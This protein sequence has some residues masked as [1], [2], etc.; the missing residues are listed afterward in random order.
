MAPTINSD[1]THCI[2]LPQLVV[3]GDQSAGKSSVLEG[4]T[5]LPFPRQDGLR[6][7][8]PTE[9]VLTH[10]DD[11][12]TT[13]ETKIIPDTSRPTEEQKRLSA[14]KCDLK[15]FRQDLPMVVE[16]VGQMMGLR[17]Y[18][19]LTGP[20]FAYGLLR[21][22][23]TGPIGVHLTVVDLPGLISVPNEEQ[24]EIDVDNVHALVE[25]YIKNSRTIILAVVQAN[26]DVANQSIIQKSKNFDRSGRR[27]VGIIMKPDLINVGTENRIAA[28]AKNQDTTKLKLGF[29]LLKNPSP[30]ELR[31][32]LTLEQRERSER[33]F[34]T[35]SPWKEQQLDADRIGVL[36]LRIYLQQLLDRHI[37]QEMPKVRK[38]INALLTKTQNDLD[39]LGEERPTAGHQR[40]FLSRLAM[41]FNHLTEAALKGEY[42]FADRAFF[43]DE[44]HDS[45][46]IRLR[47]FVHNANTEFANAMREYGESRKVVPTPV[48]P[49]LDQN[50]GSGEES[51]TSDTS[52]VESDGD[53]ETPDESGVSSFR[54][55]QQ[56]IGEREMEEFVLKVGR[57]VHKLRAAA[58]LT[59]VALP[60]HERPGVARQLQ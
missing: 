50:A 47:A 54:K 1:T 31:E 41:R 34:F 38:E 11:P 2:D 36:K 55:S 33:T 16:E 43:S 12:T 26:N 7:R 20:T 19:N 23:V 9:I 25:W 42:Q 40:M 8:F 60:A 52:P 18:G 21:I 44:T 49:Q 10:T 35:T 22:K 45:D 3:C 48:E 28:L 29:F 30:K 14:Y 32:G 58:L 17:G 39:A 27:T 51:Q 37:E 53:D 24:T 6:T 13:I 15:D 46:C 57:S 5:G 4:I 59:D 56:L